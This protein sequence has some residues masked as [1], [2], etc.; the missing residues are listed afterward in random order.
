M[1][2]SV[3]IINMNND[4]ES[5]E[6][7]FAMSPQGTADLVQEQSEKTAHYFVFSGD[8]KAGMHGYEKV[9]EQLNSSIEIIFQWKFRKSKPRSYMTCRKSL[10]SLNK[11]KN[12]I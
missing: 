3:F 9:R 5:D 6:E 2:F 11:P 7:D 1:I 8:N 4:S 10:H 12:R